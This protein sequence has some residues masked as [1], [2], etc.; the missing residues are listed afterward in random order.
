MNICPSSDIEYTGVCPNK[1]C[2]AYSKMSDTG[3]LLHKIKIPSPYAIGYYKG[4][5]S[6]TIKKLY[7]DGLSLMQRASLFYHSI[8]SES[9]EMVCYK[10]HYANCKEDNWCKIRRK[11]LNKYIKTYPF[12]LIKDKSLFW[13]AF[14]NTDTLKEIPYECLEEGK[15]ILAKSNTQ[16]GDKNEH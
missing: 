6:K 16:T 7:K 3:C 9:I 12:I 5:D 8:N 15:L 2:M 13:K 14:L 1:N 11:F 4:L 10:C